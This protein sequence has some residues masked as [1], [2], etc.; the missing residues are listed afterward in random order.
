MML[1]RFL[2]VSSCSFSWLDSETPDEAPQ[3][4]ISIS[5]KRCSTSHCC[6]A[7]LVFSEQFSDSTVWRRSLNL[8]ISPSKASWEP[9]NG[10]APDS[11]WVRD[12]TKI[13]KRKYV[14]RIKL[15]K[16]SSPCD[17]VSLSHYQLRHFL[18]WRDLKEDLITVSTRLRLGPWRVWRDSTAWTFLWAMNWWT[19]GAGWISDSCSIGIAISTMRFRTVR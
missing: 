13:F 3:I 8:F 9:S 14:R 18:Q 12:P 11:R 17:V 5:A 7:S 4:C 16:F 19:H 15:E 1:S 10:V 6:W 2:S